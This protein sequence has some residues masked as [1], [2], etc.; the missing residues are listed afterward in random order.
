MSGPAPLAVVIAA[1][2][3]ARRLPALLAQLAAAPELVAEVWVVDGQSSDATLSAARLAGAR[4]LSAPPGRGLQLLRGIEASGAPWLLLL[5]ADVRLPP[6]W[7]GAVSA[8]IST[9]VARPQ[10]WYFELAIG[11][12]AL[13]GALAWARQPGLRLVELAVRLR[14]RWRQLPYGDQ[15]LLLSRELYQRCGGIRPLPLMEDLDLVLRLQRQAQLLSL[16]LPLQ[17]DGRR[18]LQR[19]IWRTTWLNWRL[20]RAW[21]RGTSAQELAMRYYGTARDGRRRWVQGAYQKAQR[22]CR[23]SRS[24]PW[25][26]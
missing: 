22:R 24:Q 6:A 25:P 10:A 18:W 4:V 20:R 9:A 21:R 23:G 12:A 17:V 16:G 19:G 3:E 7:A 5:H 8:A 1:R 2:D 14:S 13:G 15:G 26:S 11:P